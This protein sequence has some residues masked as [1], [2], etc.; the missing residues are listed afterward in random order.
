MAAGLCAVG[1][2]VAFGFAIALYARS[3]HGHGVIA[4]AMRRDRWAELAQ[5]I[6]A[7]S[8]LVATGISYRER[9]RSPIAQR[10]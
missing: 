10:T 5:I 3:A 8:G 6:V 4:D 2:V 7:G 9:S 1:Y